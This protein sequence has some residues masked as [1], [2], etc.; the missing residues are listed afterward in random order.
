MKVDE[1]FLDEHDG[2][3]YISAL[4]SNGEVETVDTAESEEEAEYLKGEYE[5]AFGVR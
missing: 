1:I 4:Y 2:E 5:L 3:W